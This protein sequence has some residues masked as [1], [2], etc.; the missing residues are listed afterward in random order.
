MFD[1]YGVRLAPILR[2]E[3]HDFGEPQ[4]G[5]DRYGFVQFEVDADGSRV[6]LAYRVGPS[7]VGEIV[8]DIE[9]DGDDVQLRAMSD[10][11]SL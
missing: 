4:G 6:A 5:Y 7:L 9:R 2:R 8:Y 10:T 3:A 11:L 1:D